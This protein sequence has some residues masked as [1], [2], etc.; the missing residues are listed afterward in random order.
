[1]VPHSPV[2]E[3]RKFNLW[4]DAD[5]DFESRAFARFDKRG[6][7]LM[8]KLTDRWIHLAAPAAHPA[9]RHRR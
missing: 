8:R 9:M 4:A 6:V 2:R 1:M 3:S 7:M 5:L